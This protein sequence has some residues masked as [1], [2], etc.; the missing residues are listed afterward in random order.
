MKVFGLY[1]HGNFFRAIIT[2]PMSEILLNDHRIINEF[3]KLNDVE[4]INILPP[5]FK[6]PIFK[7]VYFNE[8][9]I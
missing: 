2:K 9:N 1:E 5:G 7:S 3:A 4:I 6:S 8:L